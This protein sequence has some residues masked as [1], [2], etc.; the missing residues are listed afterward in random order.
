MIRRGVAVVTLILLCVGGRGEL[1]AEPRDLLDQFRD[2]ASRSLGALEAYGA[3]GDG[4]DVR[5]LYALIDEE[6]IES[7]DSGGPFA[8]PMFIQ[9]QLDGFAEAWGGVVLGVRAVV[10]PDARAPLL[11][12]GFSLG[13]M[14]RTGSVRV[15]GRSAGAATLLSVSAWRGAPEVLEWLPTRRGEAQFLVRWTGETSGRGTRA[16][17]LDLWRQTGPDTVRVVWSTAEHFPGGLWVAG[18]EVTPGEVVLRYE[19]RYPGWK[20]GC[21]EQTEQVDVYR[22][23]PA[24]ETLAL[25]RGHAVNGWH[26]ELQSAVTR[27]FAALHDRDERTLA[28]L[29]PDAAVRG[30]LPAHLDPE[31]AC[32]GRSP[33]RPGVVTV[34]AAEERDGGAAPWSLSWA[35][36]SQGWRL[37]AVEAVLQ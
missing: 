1:V 27:F 2:L 9:G 8:S 10:G 4:A 6:V 36:L 30:R 33:G 25:A 37:A 34:A 26:R 5:P 20:P 7:L 19:T 23:Q 31:P 24:A 14:G 3:D 35:R 16:L 15:Y 17:R 12:G 22:Y 28:E 29:V 32:E 18:A 11:V 13:T 21:E